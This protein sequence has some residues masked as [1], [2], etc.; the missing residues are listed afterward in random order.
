MPSPPD[1]PFTGGTVINGGILSVNGIDD[2]GFNPSALGYAP[3]SATVLR[4]G[5]GTLQY[6]GSSAAVTARTV[7]GT[8]TIDMP[9]G[10][11]ELDLVTGNIT[12]TGGATLTLGG[13]ADNAGAGITI[14]NGK[15]ILSKA[16]TG[17]A[18]ALGGTTSVVNSPGI[19]RSEE[20]R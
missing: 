3:T 14:N 12:K 20:R 7:T 13:T 15:V 17:T 19:L 6:T 11:V 1:N 5:G 8:G 10:P 2:F 9:N 4:F 18:H 16:S